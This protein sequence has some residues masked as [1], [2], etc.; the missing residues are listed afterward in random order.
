MSP[1]TPDRALAWAAIFEAHPR[2]PPH[3]MAWVTELRTWAH[4]T[5][6]DPI[7]SENAP[8]R[9]RPTL[10]PDQV[11]LALTKEA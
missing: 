2:R 7:P 10:N 3:W 5:E 9:S 8:Q 6:I 11:N 4:E 1:L